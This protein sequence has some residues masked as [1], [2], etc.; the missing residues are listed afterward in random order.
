MEGSTANAAHNRKK[1]AVFFVLVACVEVLDAC[2]QLVVHGLHFHRHL[3]T[4]Q[5]P[6][7]MSAPETHTSRAADHNNK[8]GILD[9]T[10]TATGQNGS[11]LF[12]P[13]TSTT[14]GSTS[15]SSS[16]SVGAAMVVNRIPS[17]SSSRKQRNTSSHNNN[18]NNNNNNKKRRH[19]FGSKQSGVSHDHGSLSSSQASNGS[20]PHGGHR[21]HRQYC[22]ASPKRQCAAAM[23]MEDVEEVFDKL[24]PNQPD[25]ARRIFQ[26]RKAIAKGKNT[27]GYQHYVH[28]VPKHQRQ[29]RSM[30]TPSTPDPSLDIPAKRWQGLV[31]AWYVRIME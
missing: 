30:Q 25:H 26:R 15:T 6:A 13:T 27:A 11:M 16:S 19:S 24:D 29:P 8:M 28:E 12:L 21:R 22:P 31:K 17:T 3:P 14:Q 2:R 18:N 4:Y 9:A 23:P 7:A 1:T 20:Q 5:P 10:T